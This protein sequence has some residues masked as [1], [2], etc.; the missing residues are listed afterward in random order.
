MCVPNA[1]IQSVFCFGLRDCNIIRVSLL[2][3]GISIR[4]SR[5]GE[6]GVCI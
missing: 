4:L 2:L 3:L 1:F 6:R 5:L